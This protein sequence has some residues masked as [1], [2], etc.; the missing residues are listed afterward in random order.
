MDFVVYLSTCN[1]GSVFC[2]HYCTWTLE[3]VVRTRVVYDLLPTSNCCMLSFCSSCNNPR[4]SLLTY[5]A[6]SHSFWSLLLYSCIHTSLTIVYSFLCF[7]VLKIFLFKSS[8]DWKG[9]HLFIMSTVTTLM[10]SCAVVRSN[11]V[12]KMF[13]CHRSSLIR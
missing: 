10:V 1:F 2:F 4:S 8:R 7:F 6:S 13:W 11:F 5:H 9:Y 3:E 12:F